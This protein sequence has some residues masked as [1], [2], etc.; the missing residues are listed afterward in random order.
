MTMWITLLASMVGSVW[1]GSPW[2]RMQEAHWSSSWVGL[3]LDSLVAER[4]LP[5]PLLLTGLGT[6]VL[7]FPRLA[8][9]GELPVPP[10]HAASPKEAVATRTAS[11]PD[12]RYVPGLARGP[13][14]L[15]AGR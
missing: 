3:S 7:L 15:A 14:L 6:P 10:L 5:W 12:C 2:R 13:G 8:T 1:P 4:P 9:C 11:A